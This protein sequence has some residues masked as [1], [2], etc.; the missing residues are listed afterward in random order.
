MAKDEEILIHA[1]NAINLV[2]SFKQ[3]PEIEAEIA[4]DTS[5]FIQECIRDFEKDRPNKNDK[6]A[7]CL[8]SLR[9]IGNEAS[10]QFI[11]NLQPIKEP[12]HYVGTEKIAIKAIKQRVQK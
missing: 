2:A 11:K 6:I 4:R 7:L 3:R 1:V 5:F 8:L 12:L 9:G 10:M